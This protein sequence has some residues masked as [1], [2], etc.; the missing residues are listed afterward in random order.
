MT[1]IATDGIVM[2]ADSRVT[3]DGPMYPTEKIFRIRGSLFG[4]AGDGF[5]GLALLEWLKTKRRDRKALYEMWDKTTLGIEDADVLFIELS[6]KGIFLWNCWGIAEPVRRPSYA[7][8]S[9]AM[10]AV[11]AM[12]TKSPEDAIRTALN[13]DEF[14]GPPIQV[15]PLRLARATRR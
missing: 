15:V 9:G 13:Y 3:G 8:G 11:A 5:M 6:P 7:I 2:A 4:T 12:E 14:S 1:T 10:A